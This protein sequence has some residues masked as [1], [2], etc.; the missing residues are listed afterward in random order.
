MTDLSLSPVAQVC[1][2]IRKRAGDM[3]LAMVPGLAED[4]RSIGEA[5]ATLELR[6][7]ALEAHQKTLARA[8]LA[9]HYGYVIEARDYHALVE[10]GREPEAAADATA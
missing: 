3:R 5:F 1:A 6:T 9:K 8:T 10:L 4:L 2:R 7:R